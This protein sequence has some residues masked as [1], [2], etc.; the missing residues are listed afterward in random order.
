MSIE[1]RQ[2]YF[3]LNKDYFLGDVVVVNNEKGITSTPRIIEII[4]SEDA[5]GIKIVPTFSNWEVI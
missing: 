5:N 3:K 1:Q 4:Y 2:E